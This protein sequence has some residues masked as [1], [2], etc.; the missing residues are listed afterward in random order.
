MAHPYHETFWVV[1]GTTAP[2]IALAAVVAYGQLAEIWPGKDDDDPAAEKALLVASFAL[3][4]SFLTQGAVLGTALLSVADR[5]DRWGVPAL[6]FCLIGAGIFLLWIAVGITGV[7]R[8][9]Q[10]GAKSSQSA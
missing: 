1:A 5:R 9:G 6:P 2:V 8:I 10:R 4:I 7:V 3:V